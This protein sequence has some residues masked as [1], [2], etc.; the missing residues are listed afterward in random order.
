[1]KSANG[2]GGRNKAIQIPHQPIQQRALIKPINNRLLLLREQMKY[3]GRARPIKREIMADGSDEEF[4]KVSDITCVKTTENIFKTTD[5]GI[6]KTVK[7]ETVENTI[8]NSPHGKHRTIVNKTTNNEENS[9]PKGT[10][11]VM[12]TEKMNKSIYDAQDESDDLQS[13]FNT[14]PQ[15]SRNIS[16]VSAVSSNEEVD[17]TGCF[18]KCF[19]LWCK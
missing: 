12:T 9:T 4:K 8:D 13:M 1:M 17:N 3:D 6:Y 2:G 11:K 7:T 10:R 19:S 14:P 18:G 16:S 5:Q 15:R